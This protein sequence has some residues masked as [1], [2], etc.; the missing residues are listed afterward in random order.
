MFCRCIICTA[1]GVLSCLHKP[2][3]I[4]C[5]L[6]PYFI[7]FAWI[8]E[9]SSRKRKEVKSVIFYVVF[10]F[11]LLNSVCIWL[12]FFL[13]NVAVVPLI[14]VCMCFKHIREGHSRWEISV[15]IYLYDKINFCKLNL[16]NIYKIISKENNKWQENK[17]L[18]KNRSGSWSCSF[19]LTSL[20]F[21]V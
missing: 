16:Y 19:K 21:E 9:A 18:Y 10:L 11:V 12:I 17:T 3:T 13:S 7:F 6:R 1:N 5:G 15:H 8:C 2:I 20:E 4:L 14:H